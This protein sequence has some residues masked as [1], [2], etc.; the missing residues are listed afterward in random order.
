[1]D[2]RAEFRRQVHRVLLDLDAPSPLGTETGRHALTRFGAALAGLPAGDGATLVVT[3]GPVISLF[4]ASHNQLDVCAL[5]GQL[6]CPGFVVLGPA[7]GYRLREVV[8]GVGRS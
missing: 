3:H 7:P 2:G 6:E 5:W 8:A 4:V 1:M